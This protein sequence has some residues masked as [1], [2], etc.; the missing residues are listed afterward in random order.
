[1]GPCYAEQADAD[2]AAIARINGKLLLVLSE[3]DRDVPPANT[4]HVVDALIEANKD[5]DFVEIPNA[6]RRSKDFL[7]RN[8][9]V[10]SRA[11]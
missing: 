7:V 5:F 3:V 2:P 8:L 6:D 1:L 9:P 11:K 4:M 10:S